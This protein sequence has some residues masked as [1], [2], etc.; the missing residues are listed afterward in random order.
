MKHFLKNL[1]Q[2]V[3]SPANGWEDIAAE[4]VRPEQIASKGFYPLTFV[5]AL[6]VFVSALYSRHVEVFSLC[7]QALVTGL[8]YFLS[9]FVGT[10]ALSLFVEPLL[11]GRYDDDRCKTYTLYIVGMLAAIKTVVNCLPVS[12]VMLFF[13]PFYVALVEWKGVRYLDIKES[14]VGIFMILAIF[15]ILVPPFLIDFLFSQII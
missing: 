2:L 7:L 14:R 13:L 10:F 15:G 11:N 12:Y 4:D 8:S 6:S 9:Y 1:L 3:L 5:T